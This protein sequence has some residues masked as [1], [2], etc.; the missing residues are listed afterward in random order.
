MVF[1][2]PAWIPRRD[3]Q[4]SGFLAMHHPRLPQSFDSANSPILGA[5]V[6]Q[7]VEHQFP[8]LRV[9]GSIPVSRSIIN[10]N[11]PLELLCF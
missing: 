5:R 8:K 4:A 11:K 1:E 9:A 10:L 6:A 7:L 3:T 2:S